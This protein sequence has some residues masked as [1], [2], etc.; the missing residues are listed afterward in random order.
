MTMRLSITRIAGIDEVGRGPL[1]GP[2]L[3]A[4]V[5]LHPD[6]PIDGLKDSK[7][8]TARQRERLAVEIRV[9][10]WGWALGRAEAHE[11]DDLNILQ[12]SLLAMERAVAALAEPPDAAVVDGLHAPRIP[13]P[14]ETRVAADRDVPA[15]SAASI[16]AKVCR[17]LEMVS[18][19]QTYPGYGFARHKGYPTPQHLLALQRLGPTPI[20][21]RS[22]APVRD[23]NKSQEARP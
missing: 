9:R 14:V 17:D 5:V 21:R 13:C 12:A 15:V 1:A 4:A 22:F 16:L 19:D 3:A 10:A 11:I 6:R 20:H 18:L 8:L 2:V 23:W 7:Q